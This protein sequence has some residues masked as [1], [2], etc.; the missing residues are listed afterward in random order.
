MSIFKTKFLQAALPDAPFDGWTE[1]LMR[2]TAEKLGV[3]A[4][5]VDMEFPRGAADLAAFL[6][7]WATEEALKKKLDAPRMH[8]RIAQGVRRRLEILG[9]HREAVAAAL[10]LN[11]LHLPRALWHTA[12]KIWWAA[13]DT[14]TDH[15]HYTKR[16]LLSAVIASTTL[17]WLNDSSREQEKTWRFLAR[18]IDNVLAF[19]QKLAQVK[20][21]LKGA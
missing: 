13:G 4:A 19:G 2:R 6:G 21:F 11:A 9:P 16:A 1:A 20:S 12:D 3:P 14:A 5:R 7:D 10:K 8:E 15:N 17:Y 18:R